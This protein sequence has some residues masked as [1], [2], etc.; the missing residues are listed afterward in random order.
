[1]G[2]NVDEGVY[3]VR[4]ASE[5]AVI[6]EVT[7][8]SRRG[9]YYVDGCWLGCSLGCSL[10]CVLGL[11]VGCMDGCVDGCLLGSALG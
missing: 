4:K 10:G 7:R 5:Y 1:M 9:L 6:N 8:Y 3:L 11:V 2:M